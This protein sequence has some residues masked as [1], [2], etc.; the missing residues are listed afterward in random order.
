[1]Y[2]VIQVRTGKEEKTMDAIRRQLGEK[3]GFDIFSPYRKVLRKVK[4]VEVEKIERCFPGYLF[5]ETDSPY[6]LFKD[7]YWTPEFTKML[8][9]EGYTENFLP[10]N[11]DESRMIDILYSKNNDRI[12]EISNIEVHEG[13]LV[14]VLD[15]PLFGLT[16]SIRKVNL[17]K[18]TVVVEFEMCGRV[19]TAPLSINIITDYL[20][21]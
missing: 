20:H 2:Y 10:L 13:Q 11:P 1:M 8:G 21:K 7:L 12:T 3:E 14:K 4:G 17:H 5:V 18:R 9:R 6:E 16:G 15:G 19:V